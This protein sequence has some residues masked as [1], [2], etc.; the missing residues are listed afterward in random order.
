MYDSDCAFRNL[1]SQLYNLAIHFAHIMGHLATLATCSLNQWALDFQGN[2]E[3]IL[4]SIR[5]AKAAGGKFDV[6]FPILNCLPSFPGAARV[7]GRVPVNQ[8][9][10][11]IVLTGE[12]SLA[13]LRIGPELEI[14]GY[15]YVQGFWS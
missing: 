7:I 9:F 10:K 11:K 12:T 8:T 15:G 2:A 1:G 13:S 3:R 14:T 4:E 6:R 5:Q